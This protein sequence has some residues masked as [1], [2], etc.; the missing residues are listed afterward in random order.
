MFLNSLASRRY[1]RSL[2]YWMMVFLNF[3]ELL[4][5]CYSS[6]FYIVNFIFLGQYIFLRPNDR[7]V[8]FSTK[9]FQVIIN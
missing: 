3:I 2:S 8:S 4:K 5:C 6:E 1:L 9:N 7:N